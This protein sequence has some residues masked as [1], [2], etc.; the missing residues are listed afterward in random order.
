MKSR[1]LYKSFKENY[2]AVDMMYKT[3]DGL[4]YG[5]Q[6]TRQQNP[7]GKVE[8][9]ALKKWLDAVSLKDRKEK[10]RIAVIPKPSLADTFQIDHPRGFKNQMEIWK[11]PLDYSQFIA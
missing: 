4:L 11:I 2:P 6:V 9:S 10:I 8:I 3:K 7:T 5:L 1:V